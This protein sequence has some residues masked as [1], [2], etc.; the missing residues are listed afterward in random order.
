MVDRGGQQL[1][2]SCFSNTWSCVHLHHTLCSVAGFLYMDALS[3]KWQ[4]RLAM[5]GLVQPA[6]ARSS[7][8]AALLAWKRDV[9]IKGAQGGED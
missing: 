3:T 1:Q 5:L 9:A 8:S 6:H 4:A 7:V 2:Q